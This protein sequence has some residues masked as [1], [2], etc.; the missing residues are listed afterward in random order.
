MT[1]RRIE[2]WI[3]TEDLSDYQFNFLRQSV[4]NG[5]WDKLKV[6]SKKGFVQANEVDSPFK[7]Y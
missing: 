6:F 5:C 3:D 1:K 7:R 4:E 2:V